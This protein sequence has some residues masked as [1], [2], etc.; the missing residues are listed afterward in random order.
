LLQIIRFRSVFVGHAPADE[1]VGK[2]HDPAVPCRPRHFFVEVKVI[3][4]PAAPVR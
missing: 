4:Y 1:Q 3:N 2:A